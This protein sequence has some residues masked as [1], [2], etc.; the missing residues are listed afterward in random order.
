MPKVVTTETVGQPHW[1]V[2]NSW[3]SWWGQDGFVLMDQQGGKG[4]CGMNSI[5]FFVQPD[6]SAYV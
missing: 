2:Q 5:I 4:V 3:G 1:K 6:L